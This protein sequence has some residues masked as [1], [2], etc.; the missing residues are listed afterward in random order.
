MDTSLMDT[1]QIRFC[2]AVAGTPVLSFITLYSPA[3]LN[4]LLSSNMPRISATLLMLPHQNVLRFPLHIY[5]L[6][7]CAF[8]KV[9]FK[10]P[11]T[12]PLFSA[13]NIISTPP[14]LALI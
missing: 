14:T 1:S 8:F 12:C 10:G 4:E 13:Q 11:V 6:K 3:K 2:R 9:S 5:P 7:F